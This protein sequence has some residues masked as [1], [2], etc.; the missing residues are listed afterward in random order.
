[1][2]YR[3][4][5]QNAQTVESRNAVIWGKLWT[6]DSKKPKRRNGEKMSGCWLKS[7]DIFVKS[8]IGD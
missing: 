7:A 6:W 5:G 8:P 4:F 3:Y 1:M 2:K